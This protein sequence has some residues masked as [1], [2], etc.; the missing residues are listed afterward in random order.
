MK[1]AASRIQKFLLKPE[2]NPNA[3]T[4]VDETDA[5]IKIESGTFAWESNST[6]LSDINLKVN[7]GSLV[8]IVREKILKSL[9]HS[10]F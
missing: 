9:L 6:T 2:L 5:V 7:R 3:V 1:V 8:A 4:K 10:F